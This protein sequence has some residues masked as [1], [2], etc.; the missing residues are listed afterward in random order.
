MLQIEDREALQDR[1]FL[2][3][4]VVDQGHRLGRIQV[5][6]GVAE[7]ADVEARERAAE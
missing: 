3:D 4:V 1:V 6:V 7:A 2:D 5:E